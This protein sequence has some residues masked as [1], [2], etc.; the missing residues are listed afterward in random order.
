MP[1][2]EIHQFFFSQEEKFKGRQFSAYVGAPWW[3]VSHAPFSLLC[4][5][6]LM[7]QSG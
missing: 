2:L 1:K 4:S 7:V 3:L 6:S 5:L